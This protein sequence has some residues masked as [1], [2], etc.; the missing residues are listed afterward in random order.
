MLKFNPFTGNLDYIGPVALTTGVTGI[1]PVANGGTGTSTQFT[2][3][4]IVFAGASGVYSQDNANL[5]W[6]D[7]NNRLGIGTAAPGFTLEVAATATPALAVSF[8]DATSFSRFSFIENAD[9]KC[10]IQQIGTNF[11]TASRRGNLEL[12]SNFGNV[13]L[14]GGTVGVSVATSGNTSVGTN[15]FFVD[16]TNKRIGIGTASPGFAIE[17]QKSENTT[18][19]LR[20]ENTST[21]NAAAVDIRLRNDQGWAA[22]YAVYGGSFTTSGFAVADTAV[23][24]FNGPGGLTLA[25]TNTS[26]HVRLYA[27]ATSGNFGFNTGTFGTSAFGVI[28]IANGTAPSSSPA[29]IGQLYVESGALKYRGSSGTIT[30]LGAA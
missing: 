9:T 8:T 22:I 6:D 10:T 26:A 3:G 21:G 13:T 2:A 29:G 17:V 15:A 25:A 11:G 5:F 4:S 7:T 18:T 30:T 24:Q 1:L 12:I 23:F 19:E 20:L 28:G 27:G 14:Q 16:A